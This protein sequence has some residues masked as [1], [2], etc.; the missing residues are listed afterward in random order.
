VLDTMSFNDYLP[1]I[2]GVLLPAVV[3]LATKQLASSQF[4][5]IVLLALSAV[6]AVLVP[7]TTSDSAL[8][9]QSVLNNFLV[10]FG[11]S[12]VAYYGLLKPQGIT[13]AIQNAVPGG[14]G[15]VALPEVEELP[16]DDNF[17]EPDV[18]I[19]DPEGPP[20]GEV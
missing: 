2:V 11:T 8:D 7:L 16:W 10:V 5:N 19:E 9:L 17:E 12:V 6:S 13:D 1:F 4:K 20:E 3:A 18:D 15:P 14:V